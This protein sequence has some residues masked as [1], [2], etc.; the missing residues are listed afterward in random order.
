MLRSLLILVLLTGFCS[1]HAQNDFHRTYTVDPGHH[2]KNLTA[3]QFVNG[4]FV[5]MDLLEDTIRGAAN[6]I[7]ITLFDKKGGISSLGANGGAKAFRL[8]TL[9]RKDLFLPQNTSVLQA[10]SNIMFTAILSEN[11]TIYKSFGS[12]SGSTGQLNW[13]QKYSL[14]AGLSGSFNRPFKMTNVNGGFYL[15]TN[16]PFANRSLLTLARINDSGVIDNSGLYIVTKD[17]SS[18]PLVTT[19]LSSLE[20]T[21]D[22]TMA[23]AGYIGNVNSR[24]PFLAEFDTLGNAVLSKMYFDTLDTYVV[25]ERVKSIKLP[26]S[27][28]VL[29]G[30]MDSVNQIFNSFGFV[31]RTDT[32]G[33]VV[34]ARKID[35]G[36]TTLTR[37]TDMVV[38]I[39]NKIVVSGSRRDSLDG[40]EYHWM[41]K[42][43]LSGAQE[44]VKTYPRIEVDENIPGNLVAAMDSGNALFSTVDDGS[45]FLSFIKTNINGETTCETEITENILSD[46]SFVA[47]TLLWRKFNT[48]S[49]EPTDIRTRDYILNPP[50]ITLERDPVYCP[51]DTID[52]LFDA[53]VEYAVYYK[54]STGVEGDSASMIRVSDTEVYTVI[55][56]IDDGKQCFT[57]CDTAQ[58]RRYALPIAQISYSLGNF[59]TTGLVTLTANV[60]AEAG[61]KNIT[62]STGATSNN[63]QVGLAGQY[64]VTITDNCDE[65]VVA[66]YDLV[67]MPQIITEAG[68]TENFSA[69]CQTGRAILEATNNSFGLSPL[70]YIWSTGDTS[71]AISIG[72]GGTYTVT[73][74]DLCGNTASASISVEQAKFRQVRIDDVIVDFTNLCINGTVTVEVFYTGDANI[75]WSTGETTKSIVVSHTVPS[76]TV[77][78]SDKVCPNFDAAREVIIPKIDL[79]APIQ[80]GVD[81]PV[82]CINNEVTLTALYDRSIFSPSELTFRWNTGA[83]T[84]SI[85]ITT[86]GIYN[87]TITETNCAFNTATA[88]INFM[89]PLPTLDIEVDTSSLCLDGTITINTFLNDDDAPIA[90]PSYIWSNGATTSTIIIT[91]SGTYTV[92]VSDPQCI[93]NTV[94]ASATYNFPDGGLKYAKVFFPNTIDTLTQPFNATFGPYLGDSPCPES[95]QNYE[96]FIFNRW[97]QKVFES[98]DVATEWKGTMKN[99]NDS[100]NP[101]EV[102]IWAVKY[103][104]FGVEYELHGDVTLIRD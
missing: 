14:G 97:G 73:V 75:L 68:I 86:D 37:L 63:I 49:A 99:E 82:E 11:D 10:G 9:K 78:V 34:W 38:G 36:D 19:E 67:R 23:I 22:T 89:F 8:S 57:L 95:I 66:T 4:N 30:S 87:V 48:V 71:P 94:T 16:E 69:I 13:M 84:E 55:A 47:D 40:P 74:T 60:F 81:R 29:A 93:Q 21:V 27:T 20:S 79:L 33:E 46:I 26:D 3:T 50:I 5:S 92:T 2:T 90:N 45:N 76:V 7:I 77:T 64:M 98:F 41:A 12:F 32:M 83:T 1:L 52:H 15:A 59:C 62:W 56:T 104:I 53:T 88:S 65:V 58:L 17:S 54:W 43:T 35:F 85:Q 51:K 70:Q 42:L 25:R 80:I 39:D 18:G 44:W 72:E 28:F 102:Y 91:Q 100:R 103:T 96:F 101:T 6:D 31:I 61:V 24:L